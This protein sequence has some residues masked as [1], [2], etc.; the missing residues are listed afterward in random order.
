MSDII[1]GD[2]H[3]NGVAVGD[4]VKVSH[5]KDLYKIHKIV[6]VDDGNNGEP[7]PIFELAPLQPVTIF[8]GEHQIELYEE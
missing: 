1:A 3:G 2:K 6:E 4:I 8:R 7:Y 5:R